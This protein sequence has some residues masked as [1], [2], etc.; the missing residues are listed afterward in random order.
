MRIHQGYLPPPDT[1]LLKL[2]RTWEAIYP[3][4]KLDV[5]AAELHATTA[6]DD[7]RYSASQMSDG[8]RVALY[9]IG[10]CLA[11]P[12]DGIIVVDEPELHLHK[13]VQAPLWAAVEKLREDCAFVYITHDV[14]FAASQVSA[15]KVWLKSFNGNAWDWEVLE[16]SAALPE[17][18][19]IEVLGSRKPVAFVEGENGSFDVALYRAMLPGYLVM[20]RGSCSSVIEGVRALRSHPQFHHLEVV[21][22]VDRDRR[23]DVEIASLEK[24]GV[25]VLDVAEV[26]NLFC[27][28]EILALCSERLAR[29][30]QVDLAA[31]SKVVFDRLGSEFEGQ[32]S[33]RVSA[34]VKF[35]LNLFNDKAKGEAAIAQSLTDLVSGIDVSSLYKESEATFATATGQED[36][37]AVL[38][39]YN[40]KSLASQIG[41][42]FGLGNKELPQ[43]VMRLVA[44]SDVKRIRAALTP[45]FGA[46]ADRIAAE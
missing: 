23:G 44:G 42:V 6:D 30:A 7:T 15:T 14:D 22:I 25:F 20:P 13:S 41:A 4:R 2:K 11:A 34:E 21:G 45:Y 9:L 37:R 31:A 5:G 35:R 38:R 40:R 43:L 28:P 3:H 39:Y 46:F 18:L 19:V 27:V 33:M 26:E 1:K 10:Q 17:D 12:K 32:V 16:P 29:D 8:E 24:S 36:Y